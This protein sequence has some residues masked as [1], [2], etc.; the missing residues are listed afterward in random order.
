MDWNKLK[1]FHAAADAGSFTR[2]GEMLSL[3]QSAISRQV[4][5][6]EDE[7]GVPLF[8]RHARGLK[9]TEQGETLYRTA[10]E[11]S[12]KLAM[13]EAVLG[14]TRQKPSGSLKITTTVG[15]GSTW[16]TPRIGEFL[17]LYPDLTVDLV[18]EDRVL[19]LSMGEADIAIRLRPSTQRDLVQRK[20]LTVHNHL[21]ASSEYLRRHGSPTDVR[22]LAHHRIIAYGD[23]AYSPVP[24]VNWLI[25]IGERA[26]VQIR[27]VLNVNNVHG[28]LMAV[29]SGLGI[30]ALP[31]YTVQSNP[32]V[33]QVIPEISGPSFDAYFV[34]PDELRDS[35]KIA[36]FRDFLL[37]KVSAW[38][39]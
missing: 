11:V 36:A 14:E 35:K 21:Y 28:Q 4:S 23:D 16:L 30:A 24:E 29:E 1:I 34:Y 9:L 19:D 12:A 17:A 22:D 15:L 6:L 20:L 5:A 38:R 31:D 27:P 33:V 13:A 7:L 10:H 3:S 25:E 8:H 32:R 26:G 18:L 39:F 37:A 2:A